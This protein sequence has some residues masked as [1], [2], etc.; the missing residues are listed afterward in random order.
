MTDIV[1][2]T[3]R[4]R[5]TKH[6]KVR[7][8]SH[9]DVARLWE[10]ALRRAGVGVVYSEGFSPRPRLAFGLA[11]PTGHESDGEYVDIRLTDEPDGLA[12]LCA[13]LSDVLPDG[14]SVAAA[15]VIPPGTPSLQECVGACTWTAEIDGPTLKEATAAITATLA[16]RRAPHRAGAQGQAPGRRPAAC[17]QRTDR[18]GG[19]RR[20]G[21]DPH[22]GP[23][24]P[25]GIVPPR[26]GDRRRRSL[27][28]A[29]AGV[30]KAPMDH[31]RGHLART[32]A[33]GRPVAARR[34][35]RV[36]RRDT[37]HARG[38]QR[39]LDHPTRASSP[40]SY[41]IASPRTG[42]P[43]RRPKRRSSASP[44]SATPAPPRPPRRATRTAS[45]A[46]RAE[47]ARAEAGARPAVAGAGAAEVAAGVAVVAAAARAAATATR[48]EA[49]ATREVGAARP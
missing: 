16:R 1:G 47:A 28:A 46:A 5:F 45:A 13:R 43:R 21:A 20:P 11:L 49:T 26:G 9:R 34:G 32:C 38:P 6:G 35:A 48:A 2:T 41:L 4:F 33:T 44:R 39:G 37:P 36:M 15:D 27:V 31:R 42:R 12:L 30:P 40:T 7:F 3:A 22:R 23:G 18:G 17:H 14:L 10:R 25:S 29:A 19:G 8:T 24:H